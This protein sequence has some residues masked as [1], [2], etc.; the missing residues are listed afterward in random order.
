MH[1]PKETHLWNL[2]GTVNLSWL[3]SLKMTT[4][5]NSGR[6]QKKMCSVSVI[7]TLG[8]SIT[9]SHRQTEDDIVPQTQLLQGG[10]PAFSISPS[11]VRKGHLILVPT[12]TPVPVS[13]IH[14]QHTPH[15]CLSLYEISCI[16]LHFVP[17][18]LS[19]LLLHIPCTCPLLSL[20]VVILTAHAEE[21][22]ASLYLLH[23]HPGSQCYAS[24]ICEA[25][26]PIFL[27]WPPCSHSSPLLHSILLLTLTL[28]PG[29]SS[30]GSGSSSCGCGSQALN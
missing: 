8:P 11:P 21:L 30:S 7:F 14:P 25:W 4:H 17:L 19:S 16:P 13:L 5:L 27:V 26:W 3:W 6:K 9:T 22:E 18:P 12:N 29:S 1:D 10:K 24:F 23:L 2:I 28:A 15:P 20:P